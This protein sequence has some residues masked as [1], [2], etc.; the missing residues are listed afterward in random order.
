MNVTL[1]V[2][3]IFEPEDFQI[4]FYDN[5]LLDLSNTETE[6]ERHK[7]SAN[8]FNVLK[9]NISVRRHAFP[10]MIIYRW[11]VVIGHKHQTINYI[12]FVSES[13]LNLI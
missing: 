5:D 12:F 2:F 11:L 10:S 6:K 8:V 9:I 3:I 13:R 1:N 7:T 4:L